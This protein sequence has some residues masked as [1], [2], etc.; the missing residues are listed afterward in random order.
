MTDSRTNSGKPASP[1]SELGEASTPFGELLISQGLVP[2]EHVEA[3]LELQE[4]EAQRGLFLRLGELLVAMGRLDEPQVTEVLRLQGRSILFCPQCMAQY[5]VLGESDRDYEC[6]RCGE[7]LRESRNLTG[8][9][10]EDT[11]GPADLIQQ[12]GEERIF[13]PF[14]ILGIISRG[15]MGIIYRAR[16]RSLDRVVAMKVA[17]SDLPSE[18]EAFQQEARAVARLR[19]PNVVA[20]HEVGRVQGVN[21]FTM[22]YIEGLPLDRA[23]AAEGMSEREIVELFVAVCDAVAY[24]H[25]Q[26]LLHH[27]LKPSN[28]MVDR[29]RVPVLIDFGIARELEPSD[30]GRILQGPAVGSPAYMPPEY[31]TGTG[32]Y[33][34]AGEVYALGATLYTALAGT[35]P[36]SGFDTAAIVRKAKVD[37]PPP[38]RRVRRTID[39]GLESIVMTALAREP[40]DRYS[41]AGRLA[42]DLRRW[43]EGDEIVGQKSRYARIW[44]RVRGRVAAA[45]GLAVALILLVVSV[46]YSLQIRELRREDQERAEQLAREQTALRESLIEA[47]LEQCRILVEAERPAEAR[48]RLN[49]LLAQD[50]VGPFKG[51]IYLVRARAH[52]ALDRQAEAER[53]RRMA[54]EAGA[55]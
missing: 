32:D 18:Q 6:K 55:R 30:S 40:G 20:I 23:V 12:S 8:V 27:D 39:R 25:T 29:K 37:P 17:A 41:S 54:R 22:D 15:G 48:D 9:G 7:P 24:V 1:P 2:R 53:D 4:S 21:Y 28:V 3:A 33:G 31:L 13:G 10:V 38:L 45:L 34:V 26:G 52:E 35:P 43:L 16:Q 11:V 36:H 50:D 5:N 19:H 47:Q 44:G 51:R 14:V 49:R 46:T 42:N